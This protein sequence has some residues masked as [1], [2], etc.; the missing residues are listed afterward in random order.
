MLGEIEIADWQCVAELIDNSIDEIRRRN[1]VNPPAGEDLAKLSEVEIILPTGKT[2]IASSQISVR[3]RGRGMTQEQLRTSV[4]AG[5]TGNDPFEH[6]GLFGMGFNVATARLGRVTE[7]LTTQVG[8]SVWR[9]VRIDLDEIGED[10][11]VPEIT[12]EKSDPSTHGTMVRVTK[13][14]P[15]RFRTIGVRAEAIKSKLGEIYSWILQNTSV[16]LRVNGKV[17]RAK[18]HCVWD[19]S[20][21]VTYGTGR[22]QEQI[23]AV[24]DVDK[25][26]ADA[27]A[28]ADCGHW[29][30]I[31]EYAC[32]RCNGSH[33]IIRE[34]RIHGWVGIQRY[35]DSNEYGIDFIR[36]GRKILVN[37]KSF[38]EWVDPDDSMNRLHEYPIEIPATKGRIVGEI[39]LDHVPVDYKKDRFETSS[40][41]WILTRNYLRGEG[42]LRPQSA[43][44]HGYS[45]N[46]SVVARLF[47]G[48]QQNKPGRKFLTPGDGKSAIHVEAAE[49]GQK[50]HR[51]DA[52]YQTD[53][54]WWDAVL[55][56][57]EEIE[58][59]NS[60]EQPAGNSE[61]TSTDDAVIFRALGLGSN[62]ANKGPEDKN[63]GG[64]GKSAPNVKP[65]TISE[66][67]EDLRKNSK[68]YSPLSRT[69]RIHNI[70]ESLE[71][72]AWHTKEEIRLD[73]SHQSL[74]VYLHMVGGGE[75][76]L[77]VDP[78]H[79]TFH[80][81][82]AEVLDAAITEVAYFMG[83]RGGKLG[84]GWTLS[85]LTAAL[86]QDT[87]KDASLDFGTVQETIRSLLDEI[88]S[89][90]VFAVEE[91]PQRAWAILNSQD[92]SRLETRFA[93]RG[94]ALISDSPS[95]I[96]EVPAQFLVRL[97]DA[98]PEAFTDGNV[99]EDRF[100]NLATDDAR[101]AVKAQ[102]TSLLLD[103]T[104]IASEEKEVASLNVL[105][106]ARLSLEMLT[107]R[108]A[109]A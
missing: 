107:Q 80:T 79:D 19:S 48:Y 83:V 5:W 75:A 22:N 57:E 92:V 81:Q 50:F 43:K 41:E 102:L 84:Q 44:K 8:E 74:P 94:E 4:K 54:K 101:S 52:D 97:L 16:S 56:H 85:Q 47:R 14:D 59:K 31:E 28:C 91:D 42:P 25:K 69:Y 64:I 18:R 70:G 78:N 27:A 104:S 58:R 90:L 2:D 17:V 82:G 68:N 9:G 49:W 88:R 86:R 38:F 71:V 29:Q 7:V 106:R 73:R 37:D 55:H 23:H 100:A 36:N 99:F 61:S 24:L 45:T 26:L 35:L 67:I 20:R 103:C 66:E 21:Y 6:L 65:R 10:F 39:H 32:A 34:R 96:E 108:I 93:S 77:F 11:S 1:E 62:T 53:E 33:L 40:R 89:L 12:E 60:A 87:F 13:L 63:A 15:S 46:E 3:D 30:G 95:F 105:K 109:L 98:W 51:G 76:D 72:A